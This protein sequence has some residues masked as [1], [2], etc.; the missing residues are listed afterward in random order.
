[1]HHLLLGIDPVELGQAPFALRLRRARACRARPRPDGDHRGARAYILPLHRG[2]CRR[3]CR[4]RRPVRGTGQIRGHGAD[5]RRRHQCRDRAGQPRPRAGLL[6]AHRPRL[7]GR[8]DQ[9][10]PARRPRRHRAGARSTRSRRSP[11]SR[12]SAATSGPTI[13]ASPRPPPQTGITGICGS[14]IIEAVAE[15]RMAGHRRRPG[16]IAAPDRRARARM[17]RRAGPTPTSCTTAREA[18]RDPRDAD[19]HPRHPAGEIRALRRRAAADGR[20][21]HRQGRPRHAGRRLRRAYHPQARHGARHDPRRAADQGHLGRQ[22]RR[23]RR[24]HRAL[25][26]RRAR[27][28]REDGR[29]HPQGRNRHRAAVPGTFR[30][31]QRDPARHRALPGTG[32]DRG[33][34]GAGTTRNDDRQRRRRRVPA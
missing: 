25:Q 31:R 33:A 20:A 34:S 7:R 4:R 30:R 22:R 28:D 24:P 12:S 16:L 26:P 11:A 6:L 32:Q 21:G 15:M 8:A 13:P 17:I 18:A 23:H 10:R 1:M 29:R 19:R 9:L 3:R 27:R 2:P 5:R 14:G